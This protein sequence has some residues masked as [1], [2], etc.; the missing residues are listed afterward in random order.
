V[1]KDKAH[2]KIVSDNE[3]TIT[4]KKSNLIIYALCIIFNYGCSQN[5]NIVEQEIWEID[6]YGGSC[7]HD[8]IIHAVWL[9]INPDQQVKKYENDTSFVLLEVTAVNKSP[10]DIYFHGE[11]NI[12]R[13]TILKEN[14]VIDTAAMKNSKITYSAYPTKLNRR[15]AFESEDYSKNPHQHLWKRESEPSLI[16]IPKNER[17][18]LIFALP[19]RKGNY[20][21]EEIVEFNK[22]MY[23]FD[24]EGEKV[25]WPQYRT[26][27]SNKIELKMIKDYR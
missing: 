24:C 13:A 4:M 5:Q 19:K 16:Q 1:S 15:L 12:L 2:S 7:Y 26:I 8:T 10:I 21:I 18:N 17:K 20:R 25:T 3:L 27:E 14:Y 22:E 11:S 6:H 23:A 9:Y